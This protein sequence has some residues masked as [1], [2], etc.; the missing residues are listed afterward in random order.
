[1]KCREYMLRMSLICIHVIINCASNHAD[2]IWFCRELTVT[3]LKLSNT[4]SRMYSIKK[5]FLFI[6]YSF[7]LS[8]EMFRHYNLRCMK[9]EFRIYFQSVNSSVFETLL[10]HVQFILVSS[11]SVLSV[12]FTVTCICLFWI[13]LLFVV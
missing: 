7:M 9:S 5:R 12:I 11:N 1:M 4:C 13:I 2:E 8:L 3:D 6:K 10:I